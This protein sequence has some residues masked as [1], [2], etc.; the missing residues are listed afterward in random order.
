MIGAGRHRLF[1]TNL[2]ITNNMKSV[3]LKVEVRLLHYSSTLI[4][5]SFAEPNKTEGVILNKG[6]FE[7]FVRDLLLVKQYRVEVYVN[8]GS[9][10]NQNWILEYKGSPGNLS[11]FEDILFGNND[12]AVGV[13]VI[14]VRL[15]TEGKSRVSRCA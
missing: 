11:H 14:A 9:A 13:S 3:I 8:Q 7:T 2:I 1:Y 4:Q 5:F 6:H 15:G 12:I 10:K